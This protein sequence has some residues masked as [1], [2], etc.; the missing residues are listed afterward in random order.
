MHGTR[1]YSG[2]AEDHHGNR[3]ELME[4]LVGDKWDIPFSSQSWLAGKCSI[5][6]DDVP[7]L[8]VYLFVIFH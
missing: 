4:D 1:I 8:N 3:M 2:G 6:L 5:Y 7:R